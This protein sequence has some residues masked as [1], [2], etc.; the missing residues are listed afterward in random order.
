MNLYK[1]FWQIA[2]YL[3][4][5]NFYSKLFCNHV[6]IK[7]ISPKLNLR[8][9]KEICYTMVQMFTSITYFKSTAV[10]SKVYTKPS[11]A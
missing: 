1:D 2:S 10:S 5:F 8:T 11:L 4:L 3:C 7:I 6:I 9:W